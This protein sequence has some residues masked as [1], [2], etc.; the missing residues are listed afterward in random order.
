VLVGFVAA[1]V[2]GKERGLCE[3]RK[4]SAKQLHCMHTSHI[5]GYARL[6]HNKV[7]RSVTDGAFGY[8]PREKSF[9]DAAARTGADHQRWLHASSARMLDCSPAVLLHALP[10]RCPRFAA[11]YRKVVHSGLL[12][13]AGHDHRR[14]P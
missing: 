9:V 12:K 13:I 3:Y 5:F 2:T 4:T 6:L 11:R 10:T 1:N 8:L 7:L 14:R